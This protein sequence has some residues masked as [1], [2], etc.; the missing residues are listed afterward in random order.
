MTVLSTSVF[1]PSV[2][3]RT[4]FFTAEEDSRTIRLIRWKSDFTGCARIIITLSWMSRVR[5]WN[6][7][8]PFIASECGERPACSRL[9]DSMAWLITS[10]PTRLTSRSIRSRS[11]RTTDFALLAWD[12]PAPVSAS[13]AA[14]LSIV[15]SGKASSA[16]GALSSISG[17]G[18][19]VMTG[20]SSS[21]G[22]VG[23]G[24][25][26]S[27]SMPAGAAPRWRVISSVQSPS[28][29][30]KT[31]AISASSACVSMSISHAMNGFSAASSSSAGRSSVIMRTRHSPSA[32]SAR[33]RWK[34]SLPV[35]KSSAC[36]LK[37]IR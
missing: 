9:C 22:M 5:R 15:A 21:S 13:F 33:S 25:G 36:G 2:M 30:S 35:S 4:S 14:G 1:S 28:T 11:T 8:S 27:S 29:N 32:C 24:G 20:R 37:R 12:L 6:S 18:D 16:I 34:G 17:S 26:R 3:R 19:A 23:G 10:S 31:D 7:S